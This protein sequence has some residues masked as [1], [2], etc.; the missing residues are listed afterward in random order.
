MNAPLLKT[1]VTVKLAL[2]ALI[3]IYVA[4]FVWNNSGKPAEP[5]LFFG[6]TPATSLLVFAVI[7]FFLGGLTAFLVGTVART[8]RQMKQVR[9]VN[10]TDQLER[11]VARMRGGVGAPR[12]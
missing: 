5:W 9:Q 4:L 1:W 12:A 10:R 7:T 11:E 6:V 8:I 3:V 2:I